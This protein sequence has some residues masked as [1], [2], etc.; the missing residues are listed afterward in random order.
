MKAYM[1]GALL[2]VGVVMTSV[3]SSAHHSFAAE[4]DRAKQVRLTGIVT[5]VEWTNPHVWF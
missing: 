4:F 5:K 3:Q 1:L 2:V